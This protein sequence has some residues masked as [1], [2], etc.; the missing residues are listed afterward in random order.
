[1]EWR[2]LIQVL[3]SPLLYWSDGDHLQQLRSLL[4]HLRE[5]HHGDLRQRDDRVGGVVLG[6]STLTLRLSSLL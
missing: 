5:E 4:L 2:T 3:A 1:M 6:R